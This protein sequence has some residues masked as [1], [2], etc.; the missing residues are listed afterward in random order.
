MFK[1]LFLFVLC[2]IQRPDESRCLKKKKRFVKQI[3]KMN[4]C[5]FQGSKEVLYLRWNE[6]HLRTY[7]ETQMT[8]LQI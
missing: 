4:G 8:L 5:S 3:I 7:F 2:R 1:V 6:R